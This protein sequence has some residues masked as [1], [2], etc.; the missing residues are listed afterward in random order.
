MRLDE[1]FIHELTGYPKF[2]WEPDVVLNLLTHLAVLQGRVL[3]K[4]QQ[5]G[6]GVQQEA[7]LNALAEEIT[8]SSEIEGAI[9]NSE[10]ITGKVLQKAVFW[11]KHSEEIP[12]KTQREIMNRLLDGFEGN[13]TSGKAA[14][15]LKTSQP[16]V[17]RMLSELVEKGFLEMKGAGRSTH[18]V[19]SSR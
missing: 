4:M 9:E 11:Q 2:T 16:T 12:N 17:N 14:K 3:G 13:F 7:M 19:L 18:Y 5:F 10:E 1:Q 6:F 8:K 15:I